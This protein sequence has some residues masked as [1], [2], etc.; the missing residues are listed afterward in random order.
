MLVHT[1]D[2]FSITIS[3]IIYENANQRV[4]LHDDDTKKE[5]LCDS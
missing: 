2:T 5:Y 1:I 4:P 3:Q